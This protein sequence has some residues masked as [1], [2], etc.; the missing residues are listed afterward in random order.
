MVGRHLAPETR[1]GG[2]AASARRRPGPRRARGGPYPRPRGSACQRSQPQRSSASA[3]LTEM[4]P[5]KLARITGLLWIVTFITSIPAV[6]LYDPLLNDA[7]LH[8]RRRRRRHP[9]L[10]RGDPG[11]AA[12]HRQH[13]HRRRP[14]RALQA[15]QRTPRARL[16]HG[17]HRRV[18]VHRGRHRQR[19]GDHDAA[20]G[21]GRH[22]RQHARRPSASRSSPSTTRPSCS[23]PASS[24]A[25][26]TG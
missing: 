2:A 11:A 17:P 19:P 18:R 16:R 24:S 5:R 23:A 15:L 1:R 3:R 21:P 10:R 12:H 25:S 26:A 14:V 7:R 20:P 22:L 4:P 13:R 9:H 6:L 8:P